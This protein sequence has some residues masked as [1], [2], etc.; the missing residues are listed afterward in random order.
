MLGLGGRTSMGAPVGAPVS[1]REISELNTSA[2]TGP[3]TKRE[4]PQ[5]Q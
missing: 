3:R 5:E 4:G 1:Y 2:L